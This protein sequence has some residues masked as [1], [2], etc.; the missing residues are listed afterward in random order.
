MIMDNLFI[1][2]VTPTQCLDGWRYDCF[3]RSFSS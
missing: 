1:W 3:V 2:P